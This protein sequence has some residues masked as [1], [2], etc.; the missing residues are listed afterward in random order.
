M[1]P[2]SAPLDDILASLRLASQS[3]ELPDWDAELCREILNHFAAFAEEQIAPLDESGDGEGCRVEEGR[4][5]MPAGFAKVYRDYA[6]GGWPSLTLPE[7]FDGQGMSPL[8]LAGV[9]EIF[10]GASHA[11]QMVTGLVPGAARTVLDYGSADQQARWLPRLASGELLS[12]MCLTEPAA[13]SDLSCIRTRAVRDGDAW[14]LSGEKIFISGGDQDL[15]DGIL[16]LVLARTGESS[17][18]VRGLSLFLCPSEVDSKTNAVK[19]MRIEEKMGLH[20]SPTCQLGFDGAQ[21]ELI[22]EQGAGLKAMFT[23][24]NHARIDVSLQGVAHAARANQIASAYAR[25]R[26]QGRGPNGPV[27]IDVHPAVRSML[28]EQRALALGGRL[29]CHQALI[30][31][32]TGLS[33]LADFL[34]PVCKV[35]CTEAG[36]RSA[37]LGIQVLG[38]YGYLKEYRVEQTW[39]DARITAI[40]EGTNEIH[41]LSLA[42][43]GLKL[44]GG[45]GVQAFS[46]YVQQRIDSEAHQCWSEL[47]D[48]VVASDH[49]AL[50]APNFMQATSQVAFLAVLAD[51]LPTALPADASA[52]QTA[53]K[54]AE[55]K[56]A[57]FAALANSL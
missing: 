42:T 47:R 52:L 36:M 40:Y 57:Y 31:I 51:L 3:V 56:V 5:R 17:D 48:C 49:P 8:V 41:A 32:A 25:Q 26:V 50:F 22:G 46:A 28:D 13:G 21:A 24:M 12:T 44:N 27:S 7:Q 10:S 14:L 45:V 54:V 39:R 11:L 1:I 16:H 38:G 15:S 53:I 29:M 18:G 9:S 20:A 2:F 4:V 55:A 6:E 37:D 43:R 23:M 35:F 19:L 30:A 34:T 33:D